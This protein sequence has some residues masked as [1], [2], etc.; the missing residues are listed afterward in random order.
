MKS[1]SRILSAAGLVLGLVLAGAPAQ[2]QTQAQPSPAAVAAAKEILAMK[3]ASAMYAAAV[4]NL[5]QQ[6]KDQLLQSNLNYQK[7]LNEVAV[8]VAQKLAGREQEIGEG[9]AKVYASEFTEQELKD[10][11]TFYKSPLGQKL[12]GSEPKAIQESMAYMNQWAQQFAEIVNGEFRA[13]MRKRG[14]QI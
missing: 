5:V 8:I 13:E 2:A 3:H 14:K 12:L 7:D 10:L 6:T 9:M 11:V 4:P 1:L